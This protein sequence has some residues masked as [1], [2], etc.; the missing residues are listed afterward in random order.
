M[1]YDKEEIHAKALEQIKKHNLYFVDDVVAYIPI[2]RSKFYSD[3]P[4]DSDEL[5]TIKEALG[6]NRICSKVKMRKNWLDS[7]NA[8]LQMGLMKLLGTDEE[9]HRL[10]GSHTKSEISGP[11]GSPLV[12]NV[13]PDE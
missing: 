10:N 3:Y 4:A 7:E 6:E 9:A 1:A 12:I 2:S 5:D 13:I 8:T 11:N